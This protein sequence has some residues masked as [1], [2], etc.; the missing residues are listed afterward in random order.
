[1]RVV[2]K[3]MQKRPSRHSWEAQLR[4][5]ESTETSFRRSGSRSSPKPGHL[6]QSSSPSFL[7]AY[8]NYVEQKRDGY[9]SPADSP[10]GPKIKAFG[11]EPSEARRLS[12]DTRKE[13]T[14]SSYT[15]WHGAHSAQRVCPQ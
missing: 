1:M 3:S 8:A 12:V 14:D 15:S 2:G 6:A 13:T 7:E 11:S 9:D 4:S 5:Y 10:A